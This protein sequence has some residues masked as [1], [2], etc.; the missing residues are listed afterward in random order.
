MRSVLASPAEASDGCL[1]VFGANLTV[2]ES[3]A[4]NDNEQVNHIRRIQERIKE[5]GTLLNVILKP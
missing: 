5:R 2:Y 1:P 4:P 3:S